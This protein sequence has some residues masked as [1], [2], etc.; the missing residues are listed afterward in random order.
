MAITSI[1][2]LNCQYVSIMRLGSGMDAM[3]AWGDIDANWFRGQ[4]I[5][6]LV[7]VKQLI[8]HLIIH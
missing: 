4:K 2:I 5:M 8:G 1:L 7:H 6:S 3:L